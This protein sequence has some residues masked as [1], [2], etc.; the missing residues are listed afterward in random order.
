GPPEK[1]TIRRPLKAHCTDVAD[2]LGR[3]PIGMPVGSRRGRRL[4]GMGPPEK[5]TIRRPLKAH[6]TDVADAL[7]R[8]PIG[9]PV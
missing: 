2:A 7:G 4:L 9:M 6:C 8:V 3:V 5:I 1:I